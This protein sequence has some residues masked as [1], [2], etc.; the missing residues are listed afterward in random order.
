NT[1]MS[2]STTTPIKQAKAPAAAG[3][4]KDPVRM[5][6]KLDIKTKAVV[7][8]SQ[9]VSADDKLHPL[10]SLKNGRPLTSF[11]DAKGVGEA[12]RA[13][14]ADRDG[15]EMMKREKLRLQIGLKPNPA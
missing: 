13:L 10:L 9:L 4:E 8:N 11:R 14:E 3:S 1:Q 2:Q 12:E 7:A 5:I 15:N 6:E